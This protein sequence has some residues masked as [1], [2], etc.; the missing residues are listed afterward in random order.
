MDSLSQICSREKVLMEKYNSIS[1]TSEQ[2]LELEKLIA[3]AK[4]QREWHF[5]QLKSWISK[6]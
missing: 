3:I 1:L 6:E 2:A 4:A 5:R